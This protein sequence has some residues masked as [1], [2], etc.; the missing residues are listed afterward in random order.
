MELAN[1]LEKVKNIDVKSK[2]FHLEI[3]LCMDKKKLYFD[4]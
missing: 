1:F 2:Q 3:A 4:T